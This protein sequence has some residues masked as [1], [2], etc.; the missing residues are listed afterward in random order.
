MGM[1]NVSIKV[2]SSFQSKGIYESEASSDYPQII[3]K[4][5]NICDYRFS[6]SLY[7]FK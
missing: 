5:E 7:N 4:F 3:I 2:L 1:A 6:S